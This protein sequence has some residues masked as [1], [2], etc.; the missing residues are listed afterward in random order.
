MYRSQHPLLLMRRHICPAANAIIAAPVAPLPSPSAG[1]NGLS[2]SSHVIATAR[3][4][5]TEKEKSKMTDEQEL[6]VYKPIN[7]AAAEQRG[8]NIYTLSEYM[9][10]DEKDM[11]LRKNVMDKAS[12]K[13]DNPFW[14]LWG[15][16]IVG[17]ATMAVVFSM[18]FRQE[19]LRFDPSLQTVKILDNDD[20]PQ[21]GGPFKLTDVNGNTVTNEDLKGKWL[22]IYFGFVNCPDICPDEMRKMSKLTRHLDKRVGKDYWQPLFITVDPRRDTKEKLKEYLRDFNPRILGLTGTFEETDAAARN[23]RVYYAIPDEPGM[24]DTDY[25]I[26]HSIV[27]YLMDPNGKFVDYTTKEFS[28][29]ES[30]T[31]LLRRMMDYEQ[32]RAKKGDTGVNAR[33]AN[34]SAVAIDELEPEEVERREK[35]KANAFKP[36]DIPMSMRKIR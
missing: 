23:F 35:E 26:D 5:M 24:T 21:I 7:I 9:E 2:S 31:K 33:V 28:W 20:G 11:R 13:L 15:L 4:W 12:E 8:Q 25:L 10:M 3:R 18:R 6:A 1:S 29:N 19:R 14:L 22:Y 27:M 36:Q 17:A 16:V 30:Y 34:V 32:E